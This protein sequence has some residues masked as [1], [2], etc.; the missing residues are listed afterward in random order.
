MP[1]A[2]NMYGPDLTV[3][4]QNPVK[5]HPLQGLIFS[6]TGRISSF[7]KTTTNA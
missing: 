6:D 5:E 7:L 4:G 3:K 2:E 1:R